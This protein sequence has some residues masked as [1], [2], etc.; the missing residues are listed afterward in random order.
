MTDLQFEEPGWLSALGQLPEG[1]SLS[2]SRFLTLLEGE[3]EDA[4]EEALQ[5]LNEKH[6][7][8]N[9]TDLPVPAAEDQAAVR[10]RQEQQLVKEGRL[11]EALEEN[12]PLRL[13]L[14]ELASVPAFGDV[15]LLAQRLADGDRTVTQQL[16]N[17][18]LSRVVEHSFELTGR[19][20]LLLDLIQEGSIGLWQGILSY[21]GGDIEEHCDWQIR[22][23]LSRAIIACARE[24]GVGQKL[25]QAMEDYRSVDEQLL[26][27]LGRNPTLEEIAERLHMTPDAASQVAKTLEA[28]RTMAQTKKPQ[29][30]EEDPEDR[31]AVENTAYFQMRQR[32]AEMLSGLDE[33]DAKLLTLR[34]GLEGGK[35][36]SS[37]EVGKQLGLTAEEAMNREAAAL[38][39]LREQ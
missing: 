33:I 18:M 17:L 28:A 15:H 25:R 9:I 30:P 1:S 10:L 14:E 38:S 8:P 34:F 20:V 27:E 22:W 3:D 29:E 32:I 37:G 16:T 6:I 24:K 23:D 39:K 12:D 21:T 13:Y 36:L 2:A 26:M 11:P 19:G 7:M 35:P 4:F 31:Q 5:L